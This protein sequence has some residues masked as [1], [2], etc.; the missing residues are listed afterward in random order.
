MITLSPRSFSCLALAAAATTALADDPARILFIAGPPSHGPGLHEHLPG[1]ELLA[2]H[3]NQSGLP[4]QA[5]VS[6]GWPADEALLAAADSVVIYADGLDSHIA[7]GRSEILRRRHE[8]GKGLAILHFAVEPSEPALCALLDD[9]IGGRFEVDWSVNPI[10]KLEK[11]IL[12]EHPATRGVKP[13]A[14]EEEFYFHIRLREDVKPV[15]QGHPPLD[16]LG[17]DG[18]RSGNP[19]IRQ[20]LREGVPQTLGWTVENATGSRGFGFTGGHFHRSWAQEDYR[21][22]VL[23]AIAWTARVDVPAEGVVGKVAATPA[24]QTIGEAIAKN[25]IEDVRRHLA[26]NPQSARQDGRPGGRTP[27][28]QAVLRN[29]TEIALLLLEAGAPADG[30]DGSGRGCLHLA[31]DRNNP[32]VLA[33]LLKAKADP[34]LR[35]KA[36]WT[37]LHHAAAKNRLELA[38]LLLE[39]GADPMI[40]SEL[41]GTPLHEAAASG[42]AELI[43]LLLKHGVKRD[44]RSKQNITA[45]DIAREYKN[46]AAI[47][48]LEAKP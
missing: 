23:N 21:K 32:E 22:L 48:A 13:F 26:A 34:N 17:E 16:A 2:L 39:G 30:V 46:E 28:E 4:V 44:L 35:D 24:Y 41:G 7:N 8:A 42:G 19:A 31:V 27:L 6:D 15:L 37:P 14:M 36:G 33:A 20:A 40:L 18:P 43:E 12:P 9:A 10:W 25:D 38:T 29:R 3:L 47:R 5:T 45:L 11:A 1:C